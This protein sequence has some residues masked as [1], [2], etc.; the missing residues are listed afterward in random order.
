MAYK[1]GSSTASDIYDDG[2]EALDLIS[3]MPGGNS[4]QLDKRYN[5]MEAASNMFLLA[6]KRWGEEF[7]CYPNGTTPD[8]PVI[9]RLRCDRVDD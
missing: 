8:V 3:A 7:A 6:V 5:D 4:N 1:F 2:M 9:A